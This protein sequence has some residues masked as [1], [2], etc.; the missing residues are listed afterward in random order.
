MQEKTFT[1]V[2]RKDVSSTPA[3][4]IYQITI[5]HV[6]QWKTEP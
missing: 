4:L 2:N 1:W 5:E 6:I 3:H